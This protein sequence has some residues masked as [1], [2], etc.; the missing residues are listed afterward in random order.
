M[1]R[2][3][4]GPRLRFLKK[5]ETFYIC[6]T[7]GG[8]SRERS[9]GAADR[10]EAEVVF[11]DWL[12]ERQR[13]SGPR[14]PNANLITD[15][16]VDYAEEAGPTM[17][18][19]ERI[20]Y[21]LTPL[22]MF[23]QGKF[24]SH[25]TPMS[26]A[27]YT[28]SRA[29]SAGTVRR[30]LGVL[31]AAL[32]HAYKNNRLTRQIPVI[33]PDRPPSKERWLNRQEAAGLLRAARASGKGRG[34]LPLFILIGLYTGKRKEAILSLRWSQVDLEKG[35]VDWNPPGRAITNKKRGKNP[36]NPK[37]LAHLR[38]ARRWGSDLGPVVGYNDRPV[39]DIKKG[40]AA[41]C[42]RAGLQDT[43]PHTL[44][45][46]CATWLMN[47][48]VPTWEAAGF[49]G[50]SEETLIRVYGHQHPD[51]QRKAATAF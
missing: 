9:T 41:A 30:E 39:K 25:V 46:T 44:R 22:A 11:A 13:D 5:R 45:H 27:A 51:H 35:V 18:S 7:E 24:A 50:M 19:P 3:N 15:I 43:T 36:L 8:R 33:L 34:H 28:K 40:F 20:G 48:A 14:D 37:L 38:R 32:N 21:A 23:W 42:A 2:R 4:Q 17:S 47:A 1:P 12:R 6:W 49:L 26:C 29:R 16:L 31:R 10:A